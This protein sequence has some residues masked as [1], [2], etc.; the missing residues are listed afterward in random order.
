MGVRWTSAPLVTAEPRQADVVNRE[1]GAESAKVPTGVAPAH[2]CEGLG[3]THSFSFLPWFCFRMSNE[4]VCGNQE[5]IS[6]ASC[7]IW[8]E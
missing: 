3:S 6:A 4:N 8:S 7:G 2:G 1:S 5:A